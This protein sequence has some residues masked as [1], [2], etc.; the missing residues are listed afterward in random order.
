MSATNP[1]VLLADLENRLWRVKLAVMRTLAPELL[2]TARTQ[3]WAREELLRTLVEAEITIRDAAGARARF[4]AAAFPV[5]KRIEEF[6]VSSSS[7]PAP[8]FD[9]LAN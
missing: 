8:T 4:K 7:I 5:H 2:V 3:R 6:D 1:P 9:Y